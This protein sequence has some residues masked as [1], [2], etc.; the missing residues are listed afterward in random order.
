MVP[1]LQSPS[2]YLIIPTDHAEAPTDLPDTWWRDVKTLLPQVT[3][4]PASYNLSFNIGTEAGQTVK[5]LHLWVV[6]RPANTPGS[7]KGLARLLSE[8]NQ[9]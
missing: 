4:L 9:E 7:G 3:E 5:H 1:A 8:A 2:C 6:P